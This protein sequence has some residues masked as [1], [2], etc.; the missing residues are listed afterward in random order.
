MFTCGTP[1]ASDRYS[2]SATEE[3]DGDESAAQTEVLC[4]T[5]SVSRW[6]APSPKTEVQVSFVVHGEPFDF[7]EGSINGVVDS[8]FFTGARG[9]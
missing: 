1:I 2:R 4:S 6:S 3:Y 5:K 9:Y 7:H 8:L